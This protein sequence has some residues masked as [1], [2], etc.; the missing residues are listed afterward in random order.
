MVEPREC[1]ARVEP[2]GQRAEVE[3]GTR[4]LKVKLGD[5]HRPKS[6]RWIQVAG[7]SH[8]RRSRGGEGNQWRPGRGTECVV[9]GGGSVRLVATDES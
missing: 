4:R 9:R 8:L 7:W 5:R 2:M 6:T 1:E 3:S